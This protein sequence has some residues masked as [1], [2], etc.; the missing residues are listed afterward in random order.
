MRLRKGCTFDSIEDVIIIVLFSYTS[1]YRV[2]GLSD[3][4]YL[5]ELLLLVLLG[6]HCTR[7]R[8]NT[9]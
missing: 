6:I 1:L 4:A 3:I 8:K 9:V 5:D 7:I 2:T